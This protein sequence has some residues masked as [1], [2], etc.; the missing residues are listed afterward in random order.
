MRTPPNPSDA[1][2]DY[3]MRPID[4]TPAELGRRIKLLRI[5]RGMTLKELEERG[6]ISATHVSEI[7]RGKASPTV[8]ALARIAHALGVRPALL[9]GARMLP[10]TTVTRAADRAERMV[11]WGNAT[12]EPVTEPAAAAG[13]S[14]QILTLPIGRDPALVH[15]HEGEEWLT[16]MSGAVDVTVGGDHHLL[17]E[18]DTLHFRAE[19]LHSYSNPSS[20]PSVL[21]I[22]ARPRLTL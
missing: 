7:E 14:A 10:D 18:G 12:L 22:A 5:A 15:R 11:R 19:H 8:G 20:G 2:P 4:P 16:V 1:N 13:M 6:R 9:V 17:R 21:L 3:A